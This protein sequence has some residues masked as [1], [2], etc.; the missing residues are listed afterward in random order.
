MS[1][2]CPKLVKKG[3]GEVAFRDQLLAD[4]N[5]RWGDLPCPPLSGPVT[6]VTEL[7]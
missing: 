5:N 3:A 6:P 4:E 1:K 2:K 7:A